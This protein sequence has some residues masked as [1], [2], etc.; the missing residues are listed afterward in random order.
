ME[1]D[2]QQELAFALQRMHRDAGAP[3]TRDIARTISRGGTPMSHST[4]SVMLNGKGPYSWPRVSLL[5]IALSGSDEAVR[6]LW[7]QTVRVPRPSFRR[8][9]LAR[10]DNIEAA[11]A[12]L[13]AKL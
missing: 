2:A 1:H 12:A 11:L 3:S 9:I 5:A 8:E 7:A 6:D 4:V 10:L 13:S